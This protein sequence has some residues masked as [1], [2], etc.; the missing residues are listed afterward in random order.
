MVNAEVAEFVLM[1]MGATEY[2]LIALARATAAVLVVSVPA[3]AQSNTRSPR[4]LRASMFLP[5]TTTPNQA[6]RRRTSSSHHRSV[7]PSR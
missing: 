1:A 3:F 2:G 7:P 4:P 5:R 6:L